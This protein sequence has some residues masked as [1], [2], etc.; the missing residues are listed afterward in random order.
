MSDPVADPLRAG[1]SRSA[2]PGPLLFARYAYPP[3]ELGYCGP[4]DPG[5]LLESA[6]DGLDL[7]ELAHLATRFAGAW[8]YLELIAGCN[9]IADPL[10]ARVVEAYWVGNPAAREGAGLRPVVIAE[11]PFRGPGRPAVRACGLR[12]AP[13]RG[14]PAQLPRLC[15]VPVAGAAAGGDGG[16]PAHRARPLPDPLGLRRSR[17]RRPGHRAE[18]P[19]GFDGSRLV[20]GPEEVEVARRS[21]HG[22]GL[23]P[24]VTV[25]DMVS[26]H[27]DWVC[28]RLSPAALRWLCYCTKRNLDAV[29]S[30][31]APGPAAVCDA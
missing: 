30:L 17:D 23:A 27:W 31:A 14:V 24:P 11:R 1:A 7:A 19:L 26:L 3:N 16:R 4:S 6:S 29:N 22:V 2:A 15:G 8:P 9:G 28:D 25:G 13:G 21:L 5:A 18:P 12:R 20:L 10:D